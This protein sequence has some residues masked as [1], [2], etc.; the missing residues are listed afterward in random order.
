MARVA[1]C[2][3]NPNAHYSVLGGALARRGGVLYLA[4]GGSSG[5]SVVHAGLKAQQTLCGAHPRT[6]TLP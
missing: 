4:S 6:P 2:S 1:A 3:A 5:G